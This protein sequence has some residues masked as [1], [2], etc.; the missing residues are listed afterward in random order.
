MNFLEPIMKK[1]ELET[2]ALT[3]HIVANGDTEK[4]AYANG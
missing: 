3:E 1:E 4:V 2:I